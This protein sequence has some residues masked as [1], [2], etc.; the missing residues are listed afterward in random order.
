MLIFVLVFLPNV[1]INARSCHE[2]RSDGF[3][4]LHV[5]KLR[6]VEDLVEVADEFVEHPQVLLAAHVGLVVELVEVDQTGEDDADV[7]VVLG[8]LLHGQLLQLIA[9]VTGNDVVQEPIGLI[10]QILNLLS[11]SGA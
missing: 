3:D 8:V 6:S 2:R 9:D 1:R 5:L 7:L 4:L 10:L 11:V